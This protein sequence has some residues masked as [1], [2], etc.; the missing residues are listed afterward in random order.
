MSSTEE[1]ILDQTESIC[2]VCLK[3][4]P[5]QRVKSGETVWLKK[6]C[7]EHGAFQTVIWRG[8]PDFSAWLVPQQ[9]AHPHT[10]LHGGRRVSL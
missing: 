1:K 3:R 10:H 7:A 2:P 9:P 6:S 5:A 4:I 8:T